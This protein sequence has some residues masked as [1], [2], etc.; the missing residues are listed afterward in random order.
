MSETEQELAG[1]AEQAA[2]VVTASR[3]KVG[4]RQAV[5][6]VGFTKE[7]AGVMKWHQRVRR[8]SQK[9]ELVE[10]ENSTP[11]SRAE[12]AGNMST[13]SDLTSSTQMRRAH[14]LVIAAEDGSTGESDTVPAMPSPETR[15]CPSTPL[16]KDKAKAVV[17]GNKTRH[18]TSGSSRESC[19]SRS[20]IHRGHCERNKQAVRQQFKL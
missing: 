18:S 3:N 11:P 2:G 8:R 4:I 10:K 12:A 15:G 13:A 20:K 19:D 9:V 17:N 7:E 16:A 14:R 6:L 5:Q 1:L